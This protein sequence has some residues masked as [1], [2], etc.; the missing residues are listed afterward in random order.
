MLV[1]QFMGIFQYKHF[2]MT[3]A[4][5]ITR[6]HVPIRHEGQG[7][8][9]RCPHFYKW[10][11][12]EKTRVEQQQTRNWLTITKVLTKTTNCMPTKRAKNVEGHTSPHFQIRSGA[13]ARIL[14]GRATSK[15][16]SAV[17]LAHPR[18]IT[19]VATAEKRAIECTQMLRAIWIEIALHTEWHMRSRF[20]ACTAANHPGRRLT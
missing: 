11:D 17:S 6:M 16:I 5:C 1:P 8:G 12:T 9:G 2:R 13:T 4:D 7:T 10:L 19:Q 15:R 14:R 18:T 20:P 3:A